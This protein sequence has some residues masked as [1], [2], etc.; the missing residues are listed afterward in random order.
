[1]AEMTKKDWRDKALAIRNDIKREDRIVK[2]GK[3]CQQLAQILK[4]QRKKISKERLLVAGYSH[5]GSEVNLRPLEKSADIKHY[6]F[7]MPCIDCCFNMHFYLCPHKALKDRNLCFL[8][9]PYKQFHIDT[10]NFQ[11]ELNAAGVREAHPE[12]LDVVLVPL[13]AFDKSGTRLGYGGGCY[14]KYLPWLRND[15]LILGI[16]FEEQC[17]EGLPCEDH[18]IKIHMVA[19]A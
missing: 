4:E 19:T 13:V 7:A 9:T 8:V 16:A 2:S 1:M 12:E 10:G 3:I 5:I 15:C 6:G 14:D 17:L 18:D 11:Q